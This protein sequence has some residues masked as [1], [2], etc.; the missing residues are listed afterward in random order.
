MIVFVATV[1]LVVCAFR[2]SGKL[3]SYCAISLVMLL[4]PA[5]IGGIS[6][7]HPLHWAWIVVDHAF[8]MLFYASMIGLAVWAH[9]I[10]RRPPPM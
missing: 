1:A 10:D 8:A 4:I 2:V 9:L 5:V 7:E 6:I 3:G